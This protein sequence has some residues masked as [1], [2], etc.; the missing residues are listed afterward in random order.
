MLTPVT[1]ERWIG[2][3]CERTTA[4][5]LPMH[6]SGRSLSSLAWIDPGGPFP[7]YPQFHETRNHWSGDPEHTLAAQACRM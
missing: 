6:R 5:R 3:R 4:L 1:R 2:A 7:R